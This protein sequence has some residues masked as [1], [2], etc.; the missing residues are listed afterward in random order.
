MEVGAWLLLSSR[1]EPDEEFEPPWALNR[2]F[3]II[4]DGNVG[5][6]YVFS[7]GLANNVLA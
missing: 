1:D 5:V 7:V 6:I 2:R 3:R 4:Q